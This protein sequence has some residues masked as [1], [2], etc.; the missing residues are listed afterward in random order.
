MKKLILLLVALLPVFLYGQNNDSTLDAETT[1]VREFILE[2]N[3]EVFTLHS[4]LPEELYN[5]RLILP[6]NANPR[7]IVQH[8]P[9]EPPIQVIG[10]YWKDG[11]LLVDYDQS[12][13]P[14]EDWIDLIMQFTTLRN[15]QIQII[16]NTKK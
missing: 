15:D 12:E 8:S 5:P 11:C 9:D 10:S 2:K 1:P 16:D 3:G 7:R 6:S 14:L 13:L 4:C